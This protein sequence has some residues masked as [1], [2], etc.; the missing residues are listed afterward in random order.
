VSL[1]ATTAAAAVDVDA[2]IT[3]SASNAATMINVESIIADGEAGKEEPKKK[4]PPNESVRHR[5]GRRRKTPLMDVIE[6]DTNN[7]SNRKEIVRPKK[8]NFASGTSIFLDIQK[9][10]GSQHDDDDDKK[11]QK[12]LSDNRDTIGQVVVVHDD[13]NN[14]NN[15]YYYPV[16]G[17][18]NDEIKKNQMDV[19]AANEEEV[20][21]V[22]MR[23]MLEE[24]S[25]SGTLSME[26]RLADFSL[27]MDL[28]TDDS[29]KVEPLTLTLPASSTSDADGVVEPA[30][31]LADEEAGKD[32]GTT[33]T[34]DPSSPAA[35]PT[36]SSGSVDNA[37]GLSPSS[38]ASEPSSPTG[39][40]ANGSS[41]SSGA[42]DDPKGL[43]PTDTVTI[44]E[45]PATTTTDG[46]TIGLQPPSIETLAPTPVVGIGVS[47]DGGPTTDGDPTTDRD[48]SASRRTIG[49]TY[50]HPLL[51]NT[52]FL[53]TIITL[54][55]FY[56]F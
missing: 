34:I 44:N 49:T 7:I 21:T 30:L 46:T 25:V 42:S 45:G 29:I 52:I 6:T 15:E 54:G 12:H 8:G 24:S 55:V 27:S 10:G 32:G 9:D 47:T 31:D 28:D 3:S 48:V 23:M 33:I 11:K 17:K 14:N 39:T 13:N 5:I 43:V 51:V 16:V 20:S 53:G 1:T 56:L 50:Y 35:A 41:P 22:M 36:S 18:L 26:L 40:N 2:S 38:E 37:N 19:A 4:T